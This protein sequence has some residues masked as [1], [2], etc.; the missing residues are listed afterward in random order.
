MRR[1]R[2]PPS[3]CPPYFLSR[4]SSSSSFVWITGNLSGMVLEALS[5]TCR[6]IVN[7]RSPVR[8]SDPA[9]A[10]RWICVMDVFRSGGARM[11]F[12]LG[13]GVR[14]KAP[15]LT[16]PPP[17]AVWGGPGGTSKGVSP[18]RFL[19]GL[20]D[21]RP[22]RVV[23]LGVVPVDDLLERGEPPSVLV[24]LVPLPFDLPV[25]PLRTHDPRELFGVGHREVAIAELAPSSV[26]G[27]DGP[28]GLEDDGGVGGTL[29]RSM[30]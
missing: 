9:V 13:W 6:R 11:S 24:V 19:G 22:E 18:E 28:E 3:I 17:P 20:E 23:D 14:G 15:C 2:E 30:A 4:F 1:D 8:W 21:L 12:P 26:E 10:G 7:G 29:A 16:C 25:L 27:I 5:A